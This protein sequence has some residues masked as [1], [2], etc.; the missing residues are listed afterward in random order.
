MTETPVLFGPEAT[1][2]GMVSQPDGAERSAVAFLMF[3]ADLISRIGPHRFNVKLARALAAVGQTSL[4]FDLS[5]FGDSRAESTGLD[6]V[7]QSVRDIRSA[8]DFL[9]QSCGIHRFALFG[10]C[11][12]AVNTFAAALADHRVVGALMLDGHVYRTRWT[13]PVRR[14]K[15][16]RAASW[17]QV[18]ANLQRRLS[19]V[20][21]RQVSGASPV[22]D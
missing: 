4:R 12:G 6:F 5:G 9:E 17:R 1:L 10:I 19:S 22:A 18:A 14:W 20:V 2:V 13:T 3:N 16:F 11:S 8:M 21:T 7:A 15:R